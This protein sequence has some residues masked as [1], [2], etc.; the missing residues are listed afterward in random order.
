[1][2][3]RALIAV[4]AVMAVCGGAQAA[5]TARETL[6][7]AAAEAAACGPALP[8]PGVWRVEAAAAKTYEGAFFSID[9]PAAF[10]VRPSLA[11][12]S[13]DGY[14]SVFFAS[15]DGRAEFYV[16][17]PQWGG[18]PADIK[19][20]EAKEEY[21]SFEETPG[22]GRV[23]VSATIKARDGSYLRSFMDTS[24]TDT[25]AR[26]VFG[27]KYTDMEAYKEWKP[28]YLRFKASLKQYAD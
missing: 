24:D 2:K 7:L 21:V 8:D 13:G 6:A 16:F 1:M 23:T 12:S 27:I 22:K 17:S 25:G 19:L 26:L 11:S 28:D 20:D 18:Q 4:A 5:G 9:Y 14:D 15:P 3:A 10:S